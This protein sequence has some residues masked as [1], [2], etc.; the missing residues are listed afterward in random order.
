VSE[1]EQPNDPIEAAWARLRQGG[2]AAPVRALVQPISQGHPQFG[3][4]QHIRGVCA[5]KDGDP[6]SAK[7]L[8]IDA[9]EQGNLRPEVWLSL[10]YAA[11]ALDMPDDILILLAAML[12]QVAP[13]ALRPFL[14]DLLQALGFLKSGSSAHKELVFNRLLLPFLSQLLER[15]DM[16]A[17]LRLEVLIYQNYVK[18]R[19]EEQHFAQ[20]M[21]RLEPLFT[22]AGHYW[23][24][25]LEPIPSPPLAAPYR[26]GF[27]LHSASMLA[28]VEVLLNT[29]KGYQA[30]EDRPFEPIVYCFGGKT[31]AMERALAEI[32]VRLVMLN[33]R[34]ADTEDS[35]WRRLLSFRQLLA[36]DGVQQLVWVSLVT[37]LPLAFAMRLAP[38]QTW[39]A[40]KYRNFSQPDIDGYVT[41]SALTRF[42]E[43]HGRRWRMGLLGVDDWYDPALESQAAAIRE[44]FQNNLILMTLGRTEKMQDPAYLHAI[45]SLLQTH[46]ET[47]FL[48]AGRTESPAVAQA[49][50]AGGVYE[51][52]R[53]VG[54][55]NTRLYAQVADIF[56][57]SFPFP[58][59]FTLYQAMAAAKPV[60]AYASPEAAQTGL[61]SFLKPVLEDSEGEPED[62][63]VLRRLIGDTDSPLIAVAHT[64]EDYVALAGRLIT[65]AQARRASGQASQQF[66]ARYFSDPRVMGRS[67]AR[68]FV[69]LIEEVR[70]RQ[71]A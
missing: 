3:L 19:E 16:D 46:P 67:F 31:F 47:V 20:C 21:E 56:L 15:R 37:M 60:V 44:P 69:E 7:A 5:L 34:F 42:G 22:K 70:D 51:R 62:R 66:I 45:V 24:Q 2:A 30:L 68:H 6:K 9:I 25:A 4:A 26:I 32:G 28:H 64:P 35:E 50:K 12:P 11:A 33:E 36:E 13:D 27:F 55:V 38:V 41:G 43:L 61:W 29:L 18:P 23:R 58:C 49:F 54:W 57:D 8:L 14:K 48:W 53:F 52:T 65:D 39:W 59:G 10:G 1:I 17:A 71:F 63:I 40:M